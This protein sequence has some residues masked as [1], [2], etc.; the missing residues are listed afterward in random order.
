MKTIQ[1]D[2]LRNLIEELHA[3]SQ[4]QE[5]DITRFFVDRMQTGNLDLNRFDQ[6][7]H[8]FFAD[9]MVALDADKA[10]FC[11]QLCLATGA[12]SI[13]EAGTS[14]G[15][16][17]LYL[18]DAVRLNGG[19]TII[20]TEY[21]ADKVAAAREHFR[22]GGVESLIDL[23]EGDL[24]ETLTHIDGPVDFVL[25]DIWIEMVV[26]AME[27]LLPHLGPGAVIVC[28][29]TTAFRDAYEPYFRFLDNH[30]FSTLT[31]PFDG[32][33]ELSV[34]LPGEPHP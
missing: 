34:R 22:R 23:R 4:D 25:L 12:R 18:A 21:E 20:A 2:T 24:R 13:V 17:T 28:D 32:G 5:E 31:L 30:G 11:H 33:L 7:T 19:G 15:V 9:K 3:R 10:R 29:N 16:S 14:Y 26:P 8:H 27:I 6:E 1:D